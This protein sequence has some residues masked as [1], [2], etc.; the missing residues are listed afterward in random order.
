MVGRR[1]RVDCQVKGFEN[2]PTRYIWK[3]ADQVLQTG[4][5]YTIEVKPVFLGTQDT[6]L[7]VES[8]P[9]VDTIY[10]CTADW[11]G[12]YTISATALLDIISK[13]LTT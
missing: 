12:N 13:L 9:G 5:N 1:G 8:S 3:Y 7:Y 11:E 6:V 4:P 2:E 10:T